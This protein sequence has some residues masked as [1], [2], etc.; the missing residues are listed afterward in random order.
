MIF[1]LVFIERKT[2]NKDE[3]WKT[4][5]D[6]KEITRVILLQKHIQVEMLQAT[7]LITAIVTCWRLWL[8][9]WGWAQFVFY[10]HALAVHNSNLWKLQTAC[11]FP[12][13]CIW[14]AWATDYKVSAHEVKAWLMVFFFFFLYSFLF[15]KTCVWLGNF[16]GN[17]HVLTIV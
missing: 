4:S 16:G 3:T 5:P 17:L 12:H 14:T 6:F 8:L 10:H 15:Q 9:G 1:L 2:S 13:P 11:H 7:L